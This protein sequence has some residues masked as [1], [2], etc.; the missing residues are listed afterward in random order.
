MQDVNWGQTVA[1]TGCFLKGSQT[2]SQY[3]EPTGC[4]LQA[5]FP[6]PDYVFPPEKTNLHVYS[7]HKFL[8]I[9]DLHRYMNLDQG[10]VVPAAVRM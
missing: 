3:P 6:S 8:F 4:W 5:V 7:V 10:S 2:G 9:Y 1:I